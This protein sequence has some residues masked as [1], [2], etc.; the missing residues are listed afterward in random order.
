ML[1]MRPFH[2]DSFALVMS[3]HRNDLV[4]AGLP[5]QLKNTIDNNTLVEIA[6]KLRNALINDG[7]RNCLSKIIGEMGL[8]NKPDSRDESTY[9]G[10][11]DDGYC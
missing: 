4:Q 6:A 2:D 9:I 8:E 7:Y 1:G 11:D 10:D 5:E 3:L